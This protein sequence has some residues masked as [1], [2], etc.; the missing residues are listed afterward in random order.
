MKPALTSRTART[1][2]RGV[3]MLHDARHV[4]RRITHDASIAARVR[5]LGGHDGEPVAS[6]IQQTLQGFR[7]H[8]RHVA[9]EDQDVCILRELR[10]RL[11]HGV[12]GA[13][14][15]GLQHPLHWSILEEVSDLV[16]AMA[17]D[18]HDLARR[19]CLRRGKHVGEQRPACERVQDLG[20]LRAHAFS[21]ACG[22][23][24]DF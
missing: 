21:L 11:L 3:L 2:S 15:L 14:L 10:H 13:E 18:H 8:E 6:G 12:S 1:L 23:D 4:A 16:G 5:Q 24:D 17:V 22:Q 20:E 7:T 9:V 19:Q